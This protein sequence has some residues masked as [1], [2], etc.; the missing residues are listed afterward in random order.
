MQEYSPNSTK[1]HRDTSN[2]A[3]AKIALITVAGIFGLGLSFLGGVQF[4]KSKNT[5]NTALGVQ[6]ME[7]GQRGLSQ[8][9]GGQMGAMNG[10]IRRMG[11]LG[12]VT[13]V[14][15]TALSFKGRG[16][17]TTTFTLNSNTKVTSND[18]TVSI[19]DIKVG[20]T[21]MVTADSSDTTIAASI[22]INPTMQ[23]PDASDS[24]ST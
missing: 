16:G 17:G 15:D 2:P 21:V 11:N 1:K 23:G 12:E 10:G 3:W 6:N 5:T 19:S 13:A 20:D 8:F 7:S 9:G 4:Q 14:S 22:T 18:A 24:Q